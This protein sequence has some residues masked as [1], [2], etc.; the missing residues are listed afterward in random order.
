MQYQDSAD[1]EGRCVS[2]QR[3]R[4]HD[5]PDAE[6]ARRDRARRRKIVAAL[7]LPKS[8]NVDEL[9]TEIEERGVSIQKARHTMLAL[10]KMSLAT[11]HNELGLHFIFM[12]RLHAL[13]FMLHTSYSMCMYLVSACFSGSVYSYIHLMSTTQLDRSRSPTMPCILLVT[14]REPSR[15]AGSGVAH[16]VIPIQRQHAHKIETSVWRHVE[17]RCLSL[18]K[19]WRPKEEETRL[20]RR[21]GR[22]VPHSLRRRR[23]FV[24]ALKLPRPRERKRKRRLDAEGAEKKDT[25]LSN[26]TL[27]SK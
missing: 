11:F 23:E 21:R 1:I 2:L 8:E 9:E 10:Q 6:V 14:L 19:A 20:S 25:R 22:G 13:Y 16:T 17:G 5:Y 7:K 15:T 12:S 18:Q 24:A 26:E 3:K 4:R 27:L